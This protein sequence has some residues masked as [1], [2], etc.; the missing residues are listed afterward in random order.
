MDNWPL[1]RMR[2][3]SFRYGEENQYYFIF[4]LA[5]WLEPF[6]FVRTRLWS[7][8]QSG[9]LHLYDQSQVL[10]YLFRKE[11]FFGNK[12]FNPTNAVIDWKLLVGAACFG[13]GWGIGGLCPGPAIAMFSVF[14]IQI[15]VVWFGFM[16]I[17]Q[18][19]ANV[20]DKYLERR[21]KEL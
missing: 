8:I 15:H 4:S 9:N 6:T 5:W 1:I 16:I 20:L 17:G 18:Q 12:L 3:F 7:W 13:L 19:I 14:N 21:K 2:P 10:L 11:S